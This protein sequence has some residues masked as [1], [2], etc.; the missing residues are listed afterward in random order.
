[1]PRLA[2][3]GGEPIRKKPF[4]RWPQFDEREKTALI[5]VLE[6][7]VWGGYSPKVA[8]FEQAFAGFHEAA[9]GVTA[10]NGTVTLEAALL[11]AGIHAGDEVIVPPISFIATASAVLRAGAVPVFADI[12]ES[13]YNL[14]PARL[15]EAI[16]GRTRAIIPV[17]FAGQP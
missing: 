14:D 12:D 17:H 16:T 5:E 1:M 15:S 3:F 2:I 13:T 4:A 10:A 6:S 8:E 9:Y 11:A 7:G